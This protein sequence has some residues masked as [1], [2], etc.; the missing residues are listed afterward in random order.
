[1]VDIRKKT[2]PAYFQKVLSG[3]KKVELRLADFECKPGDVLVLEEWNPETKTYTGRTTRKKV[4]YVM[5]TKDAPF[6]TKE[7]IEKYGYLIMQ[8]DNE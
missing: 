6:W 2:W 7:E 3:E 1:M 8:L 4:S 5:K